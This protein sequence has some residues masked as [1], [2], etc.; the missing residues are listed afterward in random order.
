[1]AQPNSYQTQGE[2]KRLRLDQLRTDGGTHCRIEINA[3]QLDEYVDA[4]RRKEKFPPV[5]ARY[6]GTDYW[7]W[8]GFHRVAAAQEFGA[9]AIEVEVKP[10]TRRDA[11]LDAVGANTKHGLPRNNIDKREAVSKLLRDS[12]WVKWSNREIARCCRVSHEFVAQVREYLSGNRCQIASKAKRKGKIYTVR[13]PGKGITHKIKPEV[14]ELIRE[15]DLMQN[16]K[17]LKSLA[18]LPP[19]EQL[20]VARKIVSGETSNVE[21]AKLKAQRETRHSL[22]EQELPDLKSMERFRTLMV[23][24]P[25]DLGEG[26]RL[27]PSSHYETMPLHKIRALPIADIAADDSHLY[28]WVVQSIMREAFDL[29]DEWGFSLKSVI[30]WVKTDRD[31]D[32]LRLGSGHFFR[33]CTEH[34]LFAVRG[35]IP[36]LRNDEPNV[37]MAPRGKHSEKPDAAYELAE[38]MSP[39]PRL[40]MFSRIDREAWTCW[41]NQVGILGKR[42]RTSKPK[43]LDCAA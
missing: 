18:K 6:D 16:W 21:F 38:R 22:L 29:I 13:N 5:R 36:A 12:E 25:W 37:I 3:F 10:G 24:P 32:R 34:I 23:D 43:F 40:D 30:T 17:N 7:L 9:K 20:R 11:I 2:I 35:N 33:N 39:A 27:S 15:T 28:L 19:D 26:G 14:R 1:V 42:S 4:M 41:G 8:D 31:G